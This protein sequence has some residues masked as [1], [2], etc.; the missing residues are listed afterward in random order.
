MRRSNFTAALLVAM[1]ALAPAATM[2]GQLPISVGVGGGVSSPQG[3][4]SDN[5]D[6]GWHAMGTVALGLPLLPIGLRADVAYNRF[7][8]KTPIAGSSGGAQRV[9][10]GTLNAT[11]GLTIPLSPVTPYLIAG[12]GM[13]DVGCSG[14]LQCGSSN[15]F[16]WNA[17][18]GLRLNAVVVKAFLEARYHRVSMTGGSV[19]YVPVTLGV[20]F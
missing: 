1:A 8:A 4:F 12:G 19:Q 2:R 10:S 14:S 18:V 13:Y 17:G 7:G 3:G 5:F 15:D 16:G 11:Y 6:T 20:M 9:V